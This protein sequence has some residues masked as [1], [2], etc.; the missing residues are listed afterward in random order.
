MLASS[1]VSLFF[2]VIAFGMLA[3]LPST[4]WESAT[5]PW[6]WVLMLVVLLGVVA[7]NIRMISLSTM[8]T[9]LIPE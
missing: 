1:V 8:V 5:S 7:G 6:L 4:L 2:Y 3:M 9:M